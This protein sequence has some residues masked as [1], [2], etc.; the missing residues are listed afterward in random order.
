MRK[1]VLPNFPPSFLLLQQEGY[2]ISSCLGTG[3]T[4]LRD[5]HVHNKGAFYTALFN[6]SIGLER[7]L[8]AIVIIDHM[9][10]N[11]L[12]VPTKKQL[13]AYGHNIVELYDTCEKIGNRRQSP[14]RGR[15]N[16]DAIDQDLLLLL[17][18]FASTTRYHNLDALSASQNGLDP[19]AHWGQ[20]I[21]A[22]LGS[23]VRQRQKEK[24]LTQANVVAD[25][26]GSVT[27]TLM[28]GLDQS[29]LT[30]AE[31]L[32]LPGL[33]DQAAR[34]AVLRMVG[35]LCPLRDLL[36]AVS[37]EAYGL[38]TP[39]PPFP[40]MQEFLEWLWNDRDYVLRKKRWP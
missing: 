29:P 6:L 2:L 1:P 17:R 39:V 26:I 25:A 14:V 28:H 33:H 10:N 16:L 38:G 19:L 7:L 13:Q 22:I 40:Q 12:S 35:L 32:A 18:D 30:T 20:I 8:K 9:L 31:A 3:L 15:S 4:E 5:A 11:A 24:I 36:G 37:R 23:D 27:L 21:L 34:F